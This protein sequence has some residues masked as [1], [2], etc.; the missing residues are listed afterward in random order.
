[1]LKD[2]R[3]PEEPNGFYNEFLKNE[4]MEHKRVF[5]AL[6][7]RMKIEKSDDQLSGVGFSTTKRDEVVVRVTGTAIKQV[8]KIKF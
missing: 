3:N 2:C 8:M 4:L 7:G 5:E 6:G 1:M